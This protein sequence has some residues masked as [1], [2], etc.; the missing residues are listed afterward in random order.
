[1]VSHPAGCDAMVKGKGSRWV[2]LKAVKI[3]GGTANDR[4]NIDVY[5]LLSLFIDSAIFGNI[6]RAIS[7]PRMNTAIF[8]CHFSVSFLHQ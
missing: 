3:N 4:G 5:V 8:S 2:R 7:S 6:I 1:M